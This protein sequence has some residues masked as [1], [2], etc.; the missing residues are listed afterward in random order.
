MINIGDLKRKKV[1]SSYPGEGVHQETR[2]SGN[3]MGL[4]EVGGC[5]CIKCE[6]L[7]SLF[8]SHSVP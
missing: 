2:L 4:P 5:Q 6:T 1:G 8:L 3:I 7:M